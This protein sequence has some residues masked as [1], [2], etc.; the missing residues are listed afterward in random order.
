MNTFDYLKIRPFSRVREPVAAGALAG[1]LASGYGAV[2]YIPPMH[3]AMGLDA[4]IRFMAECFPAAV[5]RVVFPDMKSELTDSDL[6]EYE[7]LVNLLLRGATECNG[8][9]VWL[10][11]ATA[12]SCL[13]E[14]HLWQDMG[15]SDRKAL[16]MFLGKYFR[17][18]AVG[19]TRD[20]KWKKFFYKRICESSGHYAC[21]SPRCEDCADYDACFGPEEE[22]GVK[23]SEAM[24]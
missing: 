1:V 17:P 3:A 24:A 12:V 5:G 22:A 6:M 8:L 18:L 4:F 9:T 10:A 14:N 13:G 19:N 20:M 16:S 7:D 23:I 11:H 2:S 15:L 21:R